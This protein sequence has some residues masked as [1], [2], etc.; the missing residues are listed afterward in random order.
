MSRHQLRQADRDERE[1]KAWWDMN[2]RAPLHRQLDKSLEELGLQETIPK[3]VAGA[4]LKLS[5]EVIPSPITVV[6]E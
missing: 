5:V 3:I 1:V 2:V 6:S 4:K